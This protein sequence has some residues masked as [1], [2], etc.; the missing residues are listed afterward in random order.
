VVASTGGKSSSANKTASAPQAQTKSGRAKKFY[1]V[2][3]GDLLSGISDKT[4]VDIATIIKLNRDVDP[5][6][7]QA[8]QLIRLRK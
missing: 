5:Q 4:G 1:R 3:P 6:A 7:L 8:G 2:R